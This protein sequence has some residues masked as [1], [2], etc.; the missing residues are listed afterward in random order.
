MKDFPLT[1][2]PAFALHEACASLA[3]EGLPL[4]AAETQLVADYL[5]G[6]L[7]MPELKRRLRQDGDATGQ[8]A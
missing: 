8:A 1:R 7:S 4:T 5:R 2:S 3:M 6:T